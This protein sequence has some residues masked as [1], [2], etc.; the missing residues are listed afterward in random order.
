MVYSEVNRLDRRGSTGEHGEVTAYALVLEE[1]SIG[2][3]EKAFG[4]LGSTAPAD[5]G[6]VGVIVLGKA[7]SICCGGEPEV[8]VVGV[9]GNAAT[10]GVLILSLGPRGSLG[11]LRE[12]LCRVLIAVRGSAWTGVDLSMAV[13]YTLDSVLQAVRSVG[14][15]WKPLV[16]LL[17]TEGLEVLILRD[18]RGLLEE[19]CWKG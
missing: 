16:G 6:G 4:P 17:G 9:S 18:S 8:S 10:Y 3:K 15:T 1:I 7:I 2:E 14:S 5:M 11:V 13:A 19:V 12:K